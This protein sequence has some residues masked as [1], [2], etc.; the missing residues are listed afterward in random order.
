MLKYEKYLLLPLVALGLVAWVPNQAKAGVQVLLDLVFQPT[1]GRITTATILVTNVITTR[2]GNIG[3]TTTITTVI[4]IVGSTVELTRVKSHS[5]GG[6]FSG[7]IGTRPS[8]YSGFYCCC[9]TTGE[10]GR[11]RL[12]LYWLADVVV[13]AGPEALLA[14]ALHRVSG[15]RDDIRLTKVAAARA[16]ASSGFVAIHFRHLAIHQNDLVVIAAKRLKDREPIGYGLC[17]VAESFQLLQGNLLVHGV[18]F[19]NK[20][21]FFSDLTLEPLQYLIRSLFRFHL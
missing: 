5:R 19:R 9:Q 15:H 8:P 18:V 4:G 12:Q 11:Q 2:I 14:V 7:E 16:D 13:H 6:D 21:V 1:T 20:R 17:A 10:R 3:I